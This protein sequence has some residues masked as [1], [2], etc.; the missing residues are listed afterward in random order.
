MHEAHPVC[1][2]RHLAGADRAVAGRR[3]AA[4]RGVQLFL[5]SH[6]VR[7]VQRGAGHRPDEH[8]H[9]AGIAAEVAGAAPGRP[10][11]DVP[12]AQVAGHHRAGVGGAA[13]VVGQGNQVDGGLGLAGE[14]GSQGPCRRGDG[15][16]RSLAAQPAGS[17]GIRGRVDLLPG[18]RADRPGSGAPLSLPPLRQ[19]PQSAGA[20]L[21]GPG[22]PLRGAD[23]VRLLDAAGRRGAGPLAAGRQRGCGTGPGRA[24]RCRAQGAGPDRDPDRV[25]GAARA[26]NDGRAGG[27][28]ARPCGGA[29]CLCHL[30]PGGRRAPLHHCLGLEPDRGPAHVHHQGAGR[31]HQ[32]PA[33]A[34]EARHAGHGGRPLW[35][36][37]V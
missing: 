8:C 29:V 20:G 7:A 17:G 22:L 9:A 25:P 6:R 13:L 23:Q 2:C 18:G 24:D 16:H 37:H 4:P 21:S 27:R 10:G 33:G 32:P 34:A 36:F 31:P 26:A 11:Q 19:D 35:L 1:S 5:V 14:A 12:P 3:Y 30:G 15:Q 28:L